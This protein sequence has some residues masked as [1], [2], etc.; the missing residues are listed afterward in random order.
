M[1]TTAF[2]LVSNCSVCT[3]HLTRRRRIGRL[4]SSPVVHQ[5]RVLTSLAHRCSFGKH[6]SLRST[7]SATATAPLLHPLSTW[8]SPS[9]LFARQAHCDIFIF[10]S[11]SL[12][13]VIQQNCC[14]SHLCQRLTTIFLTYFADTKCAFGPPITHFSAYFA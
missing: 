3:E 10:I 2:R 11:T 6:L 5:L 7:A 9:H 12:S 4:S 13:L 1:H 14:F 8:C